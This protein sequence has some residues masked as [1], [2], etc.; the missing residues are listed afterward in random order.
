[1]LKRKASFGRPMFFRDQF[2]R[3]GVELLGVKAVGAAHQR[4]E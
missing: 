1:M 2:P 3:H 4:G